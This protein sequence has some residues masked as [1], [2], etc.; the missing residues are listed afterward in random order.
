MAEPFRL[1]IDE[2]N[3]LVVGILVTA[4]AFTAFSG[5]LELQNAIFYLGVAAAVLGVREFGQR[6]VAQW[7]DA[8]VDLNLSMKGSITTVF[9]A[10]LAILTDLPIIL[11]FPVHSSFSI[12]N[13]EQWGKGVDSMWLK[14]EAWL[15]YGGIIALLI[16]G[17]TS[18]LLNMP[19]L[20]NAF[21]LFTAFQLLPFDND[22]IPT[23]ALDGSYVLK[24]NGFYW[25]IFM[26][27]SLA[28]F[29]LL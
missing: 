25:L 27:L 6:T 22:G 5:V 8:K 20:Q 24:Q 1:S 19:K 11:P 4:A 15:A 17:F 13:Y 23:G 29:L 21:F 10:F 7:M 18:T 26:F 2:I 3:Y 16:A 9:G 28:G 14:R 12:E